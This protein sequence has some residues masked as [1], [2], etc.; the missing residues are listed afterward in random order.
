MIAPT[1]DRPLEVVE[2]FAGIGAQAKALE[3]LGIPHRIVAISEID[4]YAILAYEAIHGRVNNLGDVT[5]IEHLPHSDLLTY[6]FPCQDLS[7]AGHRRGMEAG[8]GTRSSLLWQV[9][10]LLE[11]AYDRGDTPVHLVMENV[12][13][14]LNRQNIGAF[15]RWISE[16]HD[17]GYYSSYEIMNAVDFG[18]PQSRKRCIMV[19][20]TDR[21]KFMFPRG[22]P[23]EKRLRDVMEK[24][25][26]ESYYLSEEKI[27][28]YQEHKA[29]HDAAGHNL[30]WVVRTDGDLGRTVTCDRTRNG[31][32]FILEDGEINGVSASPKTKVVG[33]LNTGYEM[34]DR[35]FS[36]SGVA[37]AMKT[38]QGG[39]RVPKILEEFE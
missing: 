39:N 15:E 12:D 21:M 26:P 19:S 34:N 11:D 31:A 20:T 30:G 14:I 38:F 3:N 32:N 10:R 8:S 9:G 18:V 5:K 22:Q 17:Y 35:V 27:A 23:T 16:L 4:K 29:R 13:A 24:S 25:V 33:S 7:V 37:P 36:P 1:E 28:K 2:L 6:S